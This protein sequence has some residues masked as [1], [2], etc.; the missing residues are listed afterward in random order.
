MFKSSIQIDNVDAQSLS[1]ETLARHRVTIFQ[2]KSHR[3]AARTSNPDALAATRA[4]E[5]AEFYIP[6]MTPHDSQGD[7][8]SEP[9]QNQD[10]NIEYEVIIEHDEPLL[11][12][13]GPL[14]E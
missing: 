14:L 5:N 13:D 1:K 9:Q 12:P 2:L 4:I 10:Q 3:R 7:E 6:D 11:E 8:T